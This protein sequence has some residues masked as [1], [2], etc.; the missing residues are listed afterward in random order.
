[1]G[2]EDDVLVRARY[3]ASPLHLLA[4]LA[5]FAVFAVVVSFLLDARE[6]FNILLWFVLAA[7]L[8]DLVLLPFYSA[9]DRIAERG[10]PSGAI[11]Y[12][13]IPAALSGL[14]LLLFF[15]AI[16]GRNDASFARVAGLEP[17]GYAGRWLLA[18][19]ILFV[20]SLALYVW[21]VTKRRRARA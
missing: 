7:V 17:S 20:V 18:T 8:H 13:R 5:L 19:A 1:V 4:H 2:R 16:L 10:A 6:P 11:N 12:I 21:N 9:L 3:G 14:M 15:P